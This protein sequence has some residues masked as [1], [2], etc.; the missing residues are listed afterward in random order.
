MT[1][2]VGEDS[3]MPDDRNSVS[4]LQFKVI[5]AS[6]IVL[7]LIW[8]GLK[9]FAEKAA[10]EWTKDLRYSSVNDKKEPN[11]LRAEEAKRFQVYIN[12]S[13]P[14][15]TV[16][17][18]DR[19]LQHLKEIECRARGHLNVTKAFYVYNYQSIALATLSSVIAAI[20]TFLLSRKGWDNANQVLVI[21]FFIS[22]STAVIA[23][24]SPALFS[25]TVVDS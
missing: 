23:G 8:F 12:S 25:T 3:T 22:F 1:A 20:S 5:T 21:I 16:E 2:P 13:L 17:E 7:I 10:D 24:T 9:V 18:R 19:L 11:Q 6:L 14:N 4:K 15:T